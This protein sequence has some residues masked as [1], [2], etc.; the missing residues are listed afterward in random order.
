MTKSKGNGG[1]RFRD[2][3]IFDQALLSKQAWRLIER[4]QSL[5]ARV[6]KSKYFPRSNLLDA[7]FGSHPQMLQVP[8]I[9]KVRLFLFSFVANESVAT[10]QAKM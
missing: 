2:M 6:N 9:S 7:G 4:P 8:S 3:R 5:Y 10:H 1:I